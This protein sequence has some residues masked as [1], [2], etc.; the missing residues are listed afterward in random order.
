MFKFQSK[1]FPLCAAAV[2]ILLFSAPANAQR[3]M[4]P[5][6][7]QFYTNNPCSNPSISWALWNESAG[8]TRPTGG[9]GNAGDCDPSN[10]GSW[11]TPPQLESNLRAYRQLM[12]RQGL[13]LRV[14][15]GRDGNAYVAISRPEGI[16]LGINAGRLVASGGGNLVAS[17]GGNFVPAA[18]LVASGGGNIIAA[19]AG[20]IIAAGAGNF[21]GVKAVGDTVVQFPGK[22]VKLG[23]N[24]PATASQ[25]AYRPSTPSY[26][27]PRVDRSAMIRSSYERALGREPSAGELSYW[28][29][30]PVNDPRV[31]S[32]DSMIQ[33]HRGY[34]RSNAGERQ[35]MINQS[36]MA[37]F[38]RYTN[39]GEMRY[40]D[41]QV[42][43]TGVTYEQLVAMHQR[44]KAQ[45]PNFR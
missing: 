7:L 42:A 1:L 9:I 36:Y 16:V 2:L 8:F 21:Y 29:G 24:S 28:N 11:Q 14:L 35:A 26:S 17:G 3:Q 32:V 6:E 38:H 45:N 13:T 10:Y 5:K 19:G 30:V 15:Q 31:A 25:P 43:S 27:A 34:L 40:W 4:T 37:V 39:A 12:A 22:W 23:S 18:T 20:N 44:Y 41:Q 33:N